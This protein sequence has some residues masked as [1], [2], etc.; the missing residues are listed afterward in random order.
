MTLVS[1][2]PMLSWLP[3]A[4][5]HA[6]GTQTYVEKALTKFKNEAK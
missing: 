4:V 6:H 2:E 3:W 5:L 1:G